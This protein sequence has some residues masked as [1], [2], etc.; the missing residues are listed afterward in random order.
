[1]E[2]GHPSA[3]EL[4]WTAHVARQ[5]LCPGSG[6]DVKLFPKRF[7]DILQVS[8]LRFGGLQ[9]RRFRALMFD[10]DMANASRKARELCSGCIGFRFRSEAQ[11][12]FKSS[13][14]HTIRVVEC[15]G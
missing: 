6:K 9:V 2:G 14:Y 5:P 4:A 11:K 1:M 3:S 10:P 12:P 7:G 8:W 13:F 15:A